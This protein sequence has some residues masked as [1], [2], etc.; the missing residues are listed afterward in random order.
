MKYNKIEVNG[1][2]VIAFDDGSIEKPFH[3]RPKRTFGTRRKDGYMVVGVGDRMWRVHRIIA[4]AFGLDLS[5]GLQVDHINGNKSDNRLEN[6]RSVTNQFNCTAFKKVAA[7]ASSKFRGVH[8]HKRK[9]RW[10]S[11]IQ[12][13]GRQKHIGYYN[14]EIEAALA[15][16]EAAKING[17]PEESL[18]LK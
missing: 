2:P 13:N 11:R 6:L 16:D 3:G 1:T 17:Y 9:G 5:G 18:N 12:V 10:H 14:N 8:W 4:S 15:Y 7:G